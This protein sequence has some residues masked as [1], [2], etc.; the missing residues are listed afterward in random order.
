MSR[1]CEPG[2]AT[3][4]IRRVSVFRELLFDGDG[5]I[6]L[7]LGNRLDWRNDIHRRISAIEGMRHHL[8]RGLPSGIL[9]VIRLF[10]CIRN[11]LPERQIG[12][13]FQFR[14]VFNCIYGAAIGLRQR[15]RQ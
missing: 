8:G 12:V 15:T 3:T 9:C 10:R 6:A 7:M 11:F 2:K 4:P 14:A 5:F 13:F 1:I